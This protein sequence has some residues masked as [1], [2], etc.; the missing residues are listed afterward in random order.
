MSCCSCKKLILPIV[1]CLALA[2]CA[3][4]GRGIESEPELSGF[5]PGGRST[6]LSGKLLSLPP[7]FIDILTENG[8][9][10]KVI[11]NTERIYCCFDDVDKLTVFFQGDYSK[12]HAKTY[13]NMKKRYEK[14]T[15]GA[16]DYYI[17]A[18]SGAGLCF[19]SKS[20]IIY[21][22]LD[23]A[24][25]LRG[26]NPDGTNL[27]A[28]FDKF[29]T[30]DIFMF[31]DNPVLEDLTSKFSFCV[32]LNAVCEQDLYVV[33]SDMCFN[34]ARQA[35]VMSPVVK[36]FVL[37]ILKKNKI[38]ELNGKRQV[39]ASENRVLLRGIKV[40][41]EKGNVFFEYFVSELENR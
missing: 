10:A 18:E 39:S 7:K 13:F 19:P 38:V 4:T 25:L 3:T 32:F 31:R 9:P 15:E 27:D 21:T 20:I 8:I 40:P 23:M 37:N 22:E 5:V 12:L 28:D 26:Y 14:K 41:V 35:K 36:L 1:L 24:E 33:D 30:G 11:E 16:F 6:Y 17:D 29:F 2:G 34:S